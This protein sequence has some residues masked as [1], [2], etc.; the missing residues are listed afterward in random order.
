[1]SVETPQKNLVVSSNTTLEL[2]EDIIIN[3]DKSSSST[4]KLSNCVVATGSEEVS[5][6]GMYRYVLTRCWDVETLPC[7]SL[8]WIM[9]NP[10]TATDKLNDPTMRRCMSFTHD[11]GFNAFHVVNLF[12]FRS[13]DPH[14]IAQ[15]HKHYPGMTYEDLEGNPR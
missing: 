1:M 8:L 2:E 3:N 7:R 11:N 9:L 15:P 12:A 6:N 14:V 10:S 5:E 4:T 13:K